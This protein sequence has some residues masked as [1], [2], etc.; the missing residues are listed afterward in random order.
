[1][2]LD[3][4]LLEL[5]KFRVENNLKWIC[6]VKWL[7]V[8]RYDYILSTD[9]KGH[10]WRNDFTYFKIRDD[11]HDIC[12]LTSKPGTCTLVWSNSNHWSSHTSQSDKSI[13]ILIMGWS[14]LKL[15]N[16]NIFLKVTIDLKYLID[17][18]ILIVLSLAKLHMVKFRNWIYLWF[19]HYIA[20]CAYEVLNSQVDKQK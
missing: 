3:S 16:V 8:F 1:M 19:A 10:T 12:G 20:V 4:L 13:I 18:T 14:I 9:P 15:I 11:G 17:V 7:L 6:H 5:E 2:T